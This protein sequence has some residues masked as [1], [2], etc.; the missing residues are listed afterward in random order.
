MD[1]LKQELLKKRQSLAEE[2]GGR[3][4]FKRSEME[5]KRIQK[6]REEE[7]REAEAKR[8]RQNQNQNVSNSSNP[9]SSSNPNFKLDS[10][11][12]K[13]ESGS[14]SSSKAAISDEQKIDSITMK[15]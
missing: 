10:I 5:Q 13:P 12:S 15:D 4:I 7:K 1:I 9:N 11:K 2:T 3:K 14:A 6:L 8:L